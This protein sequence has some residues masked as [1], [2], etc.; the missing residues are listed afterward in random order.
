[1]S[2]LI[3]HRLQLLSEPLR[4]RIL[5]VLLR[6]ELNVGELT[7]ILQTP[8]SSI[9]RHLK[10]LLEQDLIRKRIEGSTRWYSFRPE[11]LSSD[12]QNLWNVVE[13]QN[14]ELYKEDILRLQSFLALRNVDS[15]QFFK[16]IGLK[17]GEIRN[18]L[19][20]NSFLT[21]TLLAL[22]KNQKVA[23]LG[24]GTGDALSCLAPFI[25]SLIGI[26]RSKEMLE[27]AKKRLS[28]HSVDFRIGHL[29][30]LPL[31]DS[32]IQTALCMLVMH[33]V[34]NVSKAFSEIARSLKPNGHLI[35]LDICKHGQL[36]LQLNLGHKHL[37]FS[38]S[39]LVHHATDFQL[40]LFLTLPKEKEALGP[41]LFIARFIKR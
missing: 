35:L 4:L 40:D 10:Q 22:V 2:Y 9:S 33:H 5:H 1:M 17:W 32:E 37:G 27:L 13:P 15:R 25:D 26:D 36:D 3:H 12:V 23:D 31:K 38:K 19:F 21:P 20:G 41:P 16:E 8:Q 30:S 7:T 14:P 18:G 39:E 24:C 6:G 11:L 34:S 29:E 28:K